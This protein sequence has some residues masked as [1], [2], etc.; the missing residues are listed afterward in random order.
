MKIF[1]YLILLG[2][3]T[4][5]AFAQ[6]PA[7]SVAKKAGNTGLDRSHAIAVDRHGNVYV[8]SEF[9]GTVDFGGG[10]N[11]T[12]AGN[13]DFVLVK[14][15]STG[16]TL[17]A[18]RGGSTLTDRAYGV[19]V[20][21]D[22]NVYLGGEYYGTVVFG[23]DTL[24]SAGN[25]DGFLLKFNS[26]GEIQ[27]VRDIKSVS[28]TA[29]R[30]LY[31]DGNNNIFYSSY[32]GSSTAGTVILD[33]ITLTTYGQRDIMIAKYNSSGEIQWAKNFGG[34]NSSEE[35]RAVCA[36]AAG[37]IYFTGIISGTAHFDDIT[38]NG[39][40]GTDVFITKLSPSGTVLW[41]KHGGDNRNDDG[42]G[43]AVDN[44]GNVFVTGKYDSAAVFG[45]LSV[46]R[47][48]GLDAFLVKLSPSGEFQW[49]KYA[50]G[51]LSDYASDIV[52]DR[53]ANIFVLGH[54]TGT[55]VIGDDTL[56]SAGSEDIFIW[57]L[58]PDGNP[59]YVKHVQ[60]TGLDRSQAMKA[61]Y[62][63]NLYI[64]ASFQ[65]T[66]T[67]D[68]SIFT[69]AG[70]D[71]IFYARLGNYP[72]P[73][74]MTSFTAS[75]NGQDVILS[76]TTAT[77]SNNAG[78]EVQRSTD[79]IIFEVV[80]FVKGNGTSTEKNSYSYCDKNVPSSIYFYRLKQ[81][82]FDGSN[83]FSEAVEVNIELPSVFSLSQNYPN[84]FNPST[85]IVFAVPVDAAVNIVFYNS[86]G[87]KVR[88]FAG[89]YTAGSYSYIFNAGPLSSGIYFYSVY[90]AGKDGAVFSA[91]KKMVL[92]K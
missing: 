20:D 62:G 88:E 92:I 24:T 65:G 14:Y 79:N 42:S 61:D 26:G 50:G 37:N 18:K 70:N 76:W 35:G 2:F 13:V 73:V 77:E 19:C 16:N 27:W 66:I 58:T 81:I 82:D 53:S 3:L 32:F 38:L 64:A 41:A 46:D 11:L 12:S 15:D 75:V 1:T 33:T 67:V 48:Q 23:N 6:V 4:V 78:F 90:A 9:T 68:D 5:P 36:D 54:F 47:N 57:G 91:S 21:S 28:Q 72:V 39:G 7:F 43:I 71:D 89:N 56:T 10:Y 22:G 49:L 87:E 8:A 17:W 80:N 60:G 69:S 55:A 51:T 84:P 52:L 85:E 74:E 31:V 29:N 34:V 63:G 40:T 59:Y 30:G 86:I 25:L 83:S 44:A 45:S